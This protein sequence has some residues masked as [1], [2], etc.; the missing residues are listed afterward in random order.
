MAASGET[1]VTLLIG[2]GF[3]MT[4][5]AT[6]AAAA[7]G[8]LAGIAQAA[9]NVTA[10]AAPAATALNNLNKAALNIQ[11]GTPRNSSL[12]ALADA[13][14]QV[15]AQTK[16][17]APAMTAF[18]RAAAAVGTAT[19]SGQQ[20]NSFARAVGNVAMAT[21]NP[22]SVVAF[23]NAAAAL[24]NTKPGALPAFVASTQASAKAMIAA[25]AAAQPAAAGM[26]QAGAAAAGAAGGMNMAGSAA[27]ASASGL[28]NAS[29]AA[30][31][32]AASYNQVATAAANVSSR[33]S[34]LNRVLSMAFAFSGGV[35]VT[36]FIGFMSAAMIGF[37][38]RLEQ[39][40]IA[41]ATL[42]GDAQ[43]GDAFITKMMRFADV[44][45]FNFAGMED[46]AQELLAMGFAAD[47]ILP[48]LTAVGDA[49]SAL[50]GSKDTLDR[51]VMSLG[52]MFTAGRVSAREMRELTMAGIPAWQ[53]LADSMGMTTAEVRKMTE[54]GLVPAGKAV[55]LLL[56]GMESR[57]GGMMAQQARTAQGAFSTLSDTMLETMSGA[58]KPLF[59]MISQGMIA[60]ADF[61]THGGG[62]FIAPA[63]RAI[64]LVIAGALIPRIIGLVSSLASASMTIG[65]F[66]FVLMRMPIF[67]VIAGLTALGYAW[68]Q[69]FGHIRE[70]LGPLVGALAQVA[71]AIYKAADASGVLSIAV[72][73]LALLFTTKLV[74]GL[75]SAAI[76]MVYSAVT[77]VALTGAFTGLTVSAG[78]ATKAVAPFAGIGLVAAAAIGAWIVAIALLI[79]QFDKVAQGVRGLGYIILEVFKLGLDLA[80]LLMPMLGQVFGFLKGEIDKMEV[81]LAKDYMANDAKIKAAEAAS[82]LQEAQQSADPYAEMLKQMKLGSSEINDETQSLVS[83]FGTTLDGVRAAAQTSTAGAMADMAKGILDHMNAPVD[84]LVAL[85]EAFA[86]ALTPTEEIARNAGILASQELANGLASGIPSVAAA[87]EAVRQA[88]TLRIDELTG[89]AYSAANNAQQLAASVD[90]SDQASRRT[91]AHFQQLI[92]V[93][94]RIK[95][96]TS[97]ATSALDRLNAELR[98]TQQ[99]S[100]L[101]DLSSA[102]NSV[103]QTAHSYFEQLHQENLRAIDDA[104]KHK[105]A[106]LDAKAAL[107]QSP[108]TAAQKALDQ[109]R[110]QIE[111][112]RMR[113]AVATA[114]S[115]EAYRDAVLAL[116]DFLAQSHI[117][118]MQAEVDAANK[119]IDAQK[120][121]NAARADVQ[122]RAED[123][124]Y[125]DQ[126]LAFDR[127]LAALEKHLADSKDAWK[128]GN[129]QILALLSGYGITY[130][131]VGTMLGATMILNLQDQISSAITA[132]QTLEAGLGGG[133]PVEQTIGGAPPKPGGTNTA[134]KAYDV[135]A[136]NVMADQLA[137]I[138]KSEMIVPPQAAEAIRKSMSSGGPRLSSGFGRTMASQQPGSSGGGTI[139]FQVGDEKLA[140]MT[141]EAL[142]INEGIYSGPRKVV[143]NSQR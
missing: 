2:L 22:A 114:E 126:V 21:K 17:S 56:Q 42:V 96:T 85:R 80:S 20:L 72:A 11:A 37:N 116:Q 48:T 137:Y 118:D 70:T 27:N 23:S 105:N 7:K 88:A 74:I 57:F 39:A 10:L 95:P 125:R 46:A 28:N 94:D 120:D 100:A 41:F 54:N 89:G 136:W 9:N 6:G 63:I 141:D 64:G 25:N 129:E 71:S 36:T 139:V 127:D 138:H 103:K 132:L 60:L 121:A 61:M 133:P 58:V 104:V 79:T 19:Q 134:P 106:I 115:P 30:M 1:L 110:R 51:V 101:A 124:R 68:D 55:T 5:L 122:R 32:T 78:A 77:A 38:S 4:G 98:K 24:A 86:S 47:Q 67:Q 53:I 75:A 73:G 142:A 108:V 109:Q 16:N 112:W 111:E 52:Q 12:V 76:G 128:T 69:N 81:A 87:A 90:M 45:P 140:D 92:S 65:N 99:A 84:A 49:V 29:S 119:K 13:A 130:G 59:D 82:R 131:K 107:N 33:G 117:D 31:R 62:S 66:S 35:A 18:A 91:A 50:G 44:T 15:A 3:D 97:A 143:L 93:W 102:F 14:A 34:F 113:N 8:Q 43:K 123:D 83:R 40:H 26:A 135:G